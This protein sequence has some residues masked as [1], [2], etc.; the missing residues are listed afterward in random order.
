MILISYQNQSQ[1]LAEVKSSNKH[2]VLKHITN[3]KSGKREAI[4]SIFRRACESLDQF[5]SIVVCAININLR[6]T[7]YA[8]LVFPWHFLNA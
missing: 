4:C 6:L 2:S 5:I 3:Y 7:A 1:F 8:F